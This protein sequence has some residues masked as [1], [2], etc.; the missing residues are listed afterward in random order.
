M[1]NKLI[2]MG[3]VGLLATAGVLGYLYTAIMYA[4]ATDVSGIIYDGSG[5][6]WTVGGSPY[7]VT[8][9]VMV[10]SG[11]TL[12]IEPGVLV[13]FDGHYSIYVE[14]DL[15]AVG[16]DTSRITITSNMIAPTKE[17]WNRIQINSSGHAE[18]KF[19]DISYSKYGLH[20]LSSYNNI[21]NIEISDNWKYGIY[22]S[23][24]SN[25]KLT[26]NNIS[27]IGAPFMGGDAYGIYLGS[28][29]YN[30]IT[31]N[32][33]SNN[34]DPFLGGYSFGLY[35]ISST[36]NNISNNVFTLNR[37][38][39]NRLDSS[40]DNYIS[41]NNFSYNF[42]GLFVDSS[43][44]NN[45]LYNVFFYN[46]MV[47]IFLGSSMNINIT[48]NDFYRDGVCMYGEDLSY[49]DSHTIPTNNIVNEK[50]LYYHKNKSGLNIDGIPV[51][52]LI[53][54]NCTDT[55][56]KNLQIDNGDEALHVVYSTNINITDNNFMGNYYGINIFSCQNHDLIENS[57]SNTNNFGMQ[58]RQSSYINVTD[59]V[60]T[61]SWSYHGIYLYTSSD[62]NIK[63][64]NVSNS[65]NSGIRLYMSSNN[66]IIVNNVGNNM[67]GIN[68]FQSSNNK[69]YHNN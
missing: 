10:P 2:S 45:V 23:S 61:N 32:N 22:L 53:L 8:G 38:F 51:G 28:S 31:Q 26:N 18:I 16:L 5:G 1:N 36:N 12:T 34:G 50:P 59:N 27:N 29:S 19:A 58:L 43:Y 47:G 30:N 7:I 20:L 6:P 67:W 46:S 24:S 66:K 60:V 14:G 52:Q 3:I 68:L 69:I 9:D 65:G 55:D 13:K 49:Y 11:E 64:N 35:L 56:V 4:Q 21:T 33:I 48:N 37:N 25:N 41:S 40:P 54:V 44:N 39:G 42:N 15:D 62:N 17:D 57:I 63:G